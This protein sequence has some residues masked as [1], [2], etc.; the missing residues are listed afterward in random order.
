MKEKALQG[1]LGIFLGVLVF[2]MYFL[3]GLENTKIFGISLIFS[4]L[5]FFVLNV[6]YHRYFSTHQFTKKNIIFLYGIYLL[7]YVLQVIGLFEHFDFHYFCLYSVQFI[8]S[9][10]LSL[11]IR[12]EYEN[13]KWMYS[14]FL[15]SLLNLFVLPQINLTKVLLVFVG[16]F[17]MFLTTLF[18]D[19]A[20]YRKKNYIFMFLMGFIYG[21][22]FSIYPRTILFGCFLFFIV[23]RKRGIKSA[24]KLSPA[25]ILGYGISA[26][27]FS[28]YSTS[29]YSLST[30]YVPYFISLFS[31]LVF[32]FG[33]C[34]CFRVHERKMGYLCRIFLIILVGIWIFVGHSMVLYDLCMIYPILLLLYLSIFSNF[35]P[36]VRFTVSI[37]RA[38]VVSQSVGD[39]KV[40]VV[41]P[42]YNYENYLEERIDSILNQSYKIYEL[43]IL[44]DCSTD[45]SVEVIEEKM[46]QIQK[47]Y[48]DLPVQFLKNEVNSGNVF[49]QWDKSFQVANGDYLW[50]CEADDSADP[51]F[52]EMVMQGFHD[53]VILSYS[54]SLTMDENN[55]LLMPNLRPWIDV[56]QCGKW[57]SSYVARGVEELTSTFCINNTIANVSS[58]VFRL[59][60]DIPYSSYLKEAQDFHLAGDWYFYA[61]LLEHGDLAYFKKSYNYHRM[62]SK[63]VTLTTNGVMEYQEVCRIQDMIRS[64]H[65]LDEDVIL[66]MMLHRQTLEYRFRLGF[67]EMKLLNVSLE[68]VVKKAKI[69]DDV[70]LSVIVPVYNTEMYLRKCLNSV[71]KELPMRTEIIVVND[72]SPDESQTIISEYVKK[73]PGIVY[74]YKKENGGLSSAKNFGLKKAKGR[75]IIFLDS[76]DFV[77]TN[78]YSTMLKKA[79]ITDADIVYS[80][81]YELFEDGDKMYFSMK[82]Y[83]RDDEYFALLDTSL[84]AAS[85]NKMCKQSL[86]QGLYYPEGMNNEDIAVSPILFE[87]AK[88]IEHIDS[89]FY[90]YLQ[91]SGSIQNSG[92]DEKRFVIF[93]TAK[94][95][96]EQLKDSPRLEMVKGSIYTHQLLGILL[97]ILPNLKRSTR[98]KFMTMFCEKINEFEDFETNPYVLEYLKELHLSKL[99]SYI[100]NMEIQ[101]LDLYLK[102]KMM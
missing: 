87:R 67:E 73:F 66:N 96:F 81:I 99:I 52:L 42:N 48:P 91:R 26:L 7:F 65:K 83:D 94:L 13:S 5:L 97:Y 2:L 15:L 100:K 57:S 89:P 61:R 46:S 18:D 51:R 44:D 34:Y 68:E 39:N 27:F 24:I 22:L 58:V 92:F 98:I 63:S 20:I 6:C 102:I 38:N 10:L 43:I 23:S 30:N 76:D 4:I 78:M 80:D 71:L 37:T 49:K 56:T 25:M 17:T 8:S 95:C 47:V 35:P 45:R 74:G 84:M 60:K 36:L 21:F 90:Y 62:H 19:L 82:N 93:E 12:R 31:L 33:T 16:C 14:L 50:I 85:W 40:S 3:L 69:R 75:Y 32:F 54:E 53:D 88:K 11:F 70:L 79:I 101:K 77:A 86:F 29:M 55:N 64:R 72:G 59:Q 41:I 28:Q 1:F 9:L